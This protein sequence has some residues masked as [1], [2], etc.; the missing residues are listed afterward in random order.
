[1]K[2]VRSFW[3]LL[4][5]LA[6]LVGSS[7][8]GEISIAGAADLNYALQQLATEFEHKTGNQV[9]LSFGSSGN[10][11]SQIQ[12]GA[13]FD[14]FFSADVDYPE[15]LAAAGFI[16]RS[17]L[18]IYAQ[19]HLVLWVPH[20]LHLDPAALQMNLLLQPAVKR[21]AV[22]N[23]Q[24]APYGRAAIAALQHFGLKDKVQDKLVFGENISQA[25]QF[26]QSGNAQA[27][28]IALSLAMSPPMKNAGAYWE[29][30]TNSYPELRQG[31]AIVTASKHKELA[32]AFLDYVASAEGK[33]VLEQYGFQVAQGK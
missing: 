15:K 7:S 9:R 31:V 30:P 12:A 22:A 5:M 8:A 17:S 1:M 6:L 13:P 3:V 2:T 14:L 19:G 16:E 23:A 33:T 29:L 11:Y 4:L 10:L 32:Q 18:R 21:I 28:L 26:V 27:G 24:H 25:A 20:S